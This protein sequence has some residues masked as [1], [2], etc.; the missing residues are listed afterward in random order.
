[1]MREVKRNTNG[2][3]ANGTAPGPGRP[4]G[5]ARAFRRAVT[6]EDIEEIVRALV[7]AA[8]ESDKGADT[9]LLRL[10]VP[11][12]RETREECLEELARH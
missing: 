2:T 12:I 3:F 6:E 11:A 5:W 1:M 10:C 7:S 9:L 8:K 4:A